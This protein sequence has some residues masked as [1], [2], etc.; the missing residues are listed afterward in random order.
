MSSAS[1]ARTVAAACKLCGLHD[2]VPGILFP[3][4]VSS[5]VV[6]FVA[7]AVSITASCVAPLLLL[8]IQSSEWLP[9]WNAERM[10]L[11]LRWPA[12]L[13]SLVFECARVTCTSRSYSLDHVVR[14]VILGHANVRGMVQRAAAIVFVLDLP[15][16]NSIETN[17][18]RRFARVEKNILSVLSCRRRSGDPQSF[19]SHGTRI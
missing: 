4:F 15:N 8:R 2:A 19:S 7:S 1:A 3:V 13:A 6:F 5:E 17:T 14:H 9:R 18:M 12:I 10:R 16:V 11:S